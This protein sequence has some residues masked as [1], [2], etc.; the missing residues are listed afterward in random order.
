M[1][2]NSARANTNANTNRLKHCLATYSYLIRYHPPLFEIKEFLIC[3]TKHA[4]SV[5]NAEIWNS[6]KG[7]EYNPQCSCFTSLYWMKLTL[8]PLHNLHTQN[9]TNTSSITFWMGCSELEE[10]LWWIKL[11]VLVLSFE[12]RGW[13]PCHLWDWLPL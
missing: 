9:V 7:E 10:H 3:Q 2:C 4:L 1:L 8:A 13:L 6:T 12:D 5:T 11:N